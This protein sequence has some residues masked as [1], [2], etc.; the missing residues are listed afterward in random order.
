VLADRSKFFTNVSSKQ[1]RKMR[2]ELVWFGSVEMLYAVSLEVI[3]NQD[4]RT[5]RF[6]LKKTAEDINGEIRNSPLLIR[7]V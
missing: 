5:T 2:I 6:A 3:E 7:L 4:I 1:N